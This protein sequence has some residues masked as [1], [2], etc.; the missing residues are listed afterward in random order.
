MSTHDY[1]TRIVIER[2]QQDIRCIDSIGRIDP[3]PQSA[4]WYRAI[5]RLAAL[6]ATKLEAINAEA[7][8]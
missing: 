3:D 1:G 8:L 5:E 4:R 2:I 7:A 6:A